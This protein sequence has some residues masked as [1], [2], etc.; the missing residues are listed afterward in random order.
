MLIL[1]V[2]IGHLSGFSSQEDTDRVERKRSLSVRSKGQRA[3]GSEALQKRPPVQG[4]TAHADPAWISHVLMIIINFSFFVFIVFDLWYNLFL[5]GC[6]ALF[7][8]I[9]KARCS[10]V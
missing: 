4:R 10:S 7:L 8:F 2:V 5:F 3:E 9:C 1:G 6:F